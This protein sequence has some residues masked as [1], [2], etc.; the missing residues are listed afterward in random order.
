MQGSY[1][2]SKA[3]S[4][5]NGTLAGAV[6]ANSNDPNNMA[7]QYGP[8]YFSHPQRFI[9][10]Y[11]YDLPFG[12][13]TGA[14]GWIANGW[15]LGGVTTIQDGTPLTITDT[16]DGTIFGVGA[17]GQQRAEI[18]PGATYASAATSGGVEA[19]L[20]GIS[21]GPGY[22]NP[23][24]FATGCLAPAIGDGT[25]WGNSGVGILLGPGNFNFDV[26]LVKTTHITERQTLVFR[27]EAFNLFNHP[28]FMNPA[29]LA[30]STPAT[31]GQISTT[32]VNPRVM[33]LGLKYI[34]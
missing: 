2:W 18:C 12:Q 4:D 10:N 28:Q 13:H 19:R 17:N 33:Q 31:F 25:G 22:I 34:F 14:L 5:V 6:S 30:V 8:A 26:T 27:A 9:L 11:S 20:G 24:A 15:N 21:G 3:L 23:S 16:R 1:T 29:T 7:Q 32:S